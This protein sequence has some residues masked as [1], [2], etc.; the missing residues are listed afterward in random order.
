MIRLH[1]PNLADALPD[2]DLRAVLVARQRDAASLEA[3]DP[4][5]KSRWDSFVQGTGHNARLGP[6]VRDAVC[7]F[8]HGKC[9][10][11]EGVAAA[12]LDHLWPKAQHPGR[13]FDWGNVLLSCRDCNAIKRTDFPLDAAGEPLQLDPSV[14]EPLAHLRWDALTGECVFSPNDA[15]ARH[16][17]AAFALDRLARERLEKLKNVRF[18]LAQAVQPGGATPEVRERLRAELDVARPYLGAVRAYLLYP[19]DARERRLV[20]RAVIAVPEILQWVAPWLQPPR[21]AA[22]PP[23]PREGMAPPARDR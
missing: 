15:R 7:A 5:I 17:V 19:P 16:T 20:A 1:R 11:C 13:M 2:E 6:A 14:D 18:L 21:D 23:A 10:Y 4:K 22:W 3:G 12:T 9:A 8:C